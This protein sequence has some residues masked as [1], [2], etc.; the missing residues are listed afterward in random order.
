M[1][2][3][4]IQNALKFNRFSVTKCNVDCDPDIKSED[5]QD[6]SIK[7]RFG[8]SF[9]EAEKNKFR[10]SF[11]ISLAKKGPRNLFIDIE[12]FCEFLTSD[13][14]DENFK[15]SDFAS[16][17]APAI[18]FPFLRSFIQTLCVNMGIPPIVLPSFN[19]AAAKMI[20]D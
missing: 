7:F 18:G 6:I 15:M 5:L 16:I 8:P 9:S 12:A 19:F 4:K 14:I 2:S 13:P 10:V 20:Q 3:P 17:N 11:I 1:K